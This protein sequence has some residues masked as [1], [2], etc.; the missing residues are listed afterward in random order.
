MKKIYI[1]WI[2]LGCLFSACS[3]DD[4]NVFDDNA[5]VRVQK[6]ID[7]CAK[8]LQ[9]PPFGW[10]MVYVPNPKTHGGYNVLMNFT[11][12]ENVEI[13]TDFLEERSTSTYRFNASQGPVLSFD[14]YSCLHYLADPKNKPTGKGLQ[15]EFEFVIQEVTS[16]SLVFLGKK[17]GAR[18]VFL[19][20][21]ETDWT[22]LMEASRVNIERLAPMENAPFFRG[23]TMNQTAVNLI[24]DPGTRS[25]SYTYA[26]DQSQKIITEKTAV[27]G[28]LEG[29][30]FLPKIRVNG[31]VLG[32]LKYNEDKGAFEANT[33]GVIGSLKYSHKPP[34]RFYNSLNDMRKGSNVVGLTKLG[35]FEPS[36]AIMN[37]IVKMLSQMSEMCQELKQ[38][39]PMFVLAGLKQFRITW[40]LDINGQNV[41]PWLTYFGSENL[42]AEPE[43]EVNYGLDMVEMRDDQVR[44]T[45]N[46]KEKTNNDKFQTNMENQA[47]FSAFQRFFTDDAGFTVVPAGDGKFYFVNLADSR[48][49]IVLTKE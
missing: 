22:E 5:V 7:R 42:F 9:E 37:E 44:F 30:A 3:V 39:Y 10:R 2:L 11:D 45:L 17:Y 43:C 20:A 4:D 25:A 6:V 21:K 28:T 27:Y 32:E 24:Y 36:M 33:P 38:D 46:G 41:G 13:F 47:G 35:K 15:G 8:T 49:W 18:I 26:D 34:F 29:V 40:G 1:I 12:E 48:R 23:L 16:D 14:T 31:V 19:P